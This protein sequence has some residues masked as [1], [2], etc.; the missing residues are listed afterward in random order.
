MRALGAELGVEAMALYR[1][2]ANRDELLEAIGERLL[3]SLRELSFSGGWR[4]AC[5]EFA[6][7]LR[8]LAMTKPATFA[9]MGFRPLDTTNS[10]AVVER[11][12]TVLV[13]HGFTAPDALA[14]YRAVASYAR[15]Y[16][17]A[18]A[19]GFT[20]DAAGPAGRKRLR[21]LPAGRFPILRRQIEELS[22]LDA[23][24]GF[25]RGLDALVRGLHEPG[26]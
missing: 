16:A 19:T 10:L 23:D 15:G 12:L 4:A 2:V 18:E 7:A 25:R 8:E 17:L 21:T 9:L 20:V 1:H 11:L 14:I 22:T 26:R 13:D 6:A 24:T 3:D 5:E